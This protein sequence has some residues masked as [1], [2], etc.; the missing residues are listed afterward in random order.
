MRL[1]SRGAEA[2]WLEASAESL[3]ALAPNEVL[4][5]V[6]ACGVC[7]TDL[8]IV[9]GDLPA[10][11]PQVVPGHQAV[12][13]VASIGSEV[14]SWQ[15]GDRVATTWL[16]WADG[17]CPYCRSGREN[18]CPQARLTG[19]DVD[20]GFATQ[21]RV[22]QDFLIRLPDAI[23]DVEAAPLMCAGVIGYR[24]LRLAGVAPGMRLGLYGFGASAHLAIQAARVAGAV[25]HV[26]SRSAGDLALARQLGATSTGAYDEPP[27][28]PL[29]AAIT[30]APVGSVVIDALRALAPGGRV[31]INAIHLDGIPAFDYDLLWGERAI[32]SV[33]NVTRQDAREFLEL[34]AQHGIR[35][36]A[37]HY[38]LADANAALQDLAAGTI[39]APSAVL[40]P[41]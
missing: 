10:H 4:L 22:H 30:F 5:E 2:P 6:S 40:V 3:P 32:G 23:S 27:P 18:L 24:A 31:V 15:V 13:R 1:R 28:E 17:T 7:R 8:Q 19:W 26:A 41:G 14:T 12:G 33:A 11:A 20:G 21:V 37:R 34:A 36:T 38:P 29:D 39:G 35:A 25:V 9:Q 16:A